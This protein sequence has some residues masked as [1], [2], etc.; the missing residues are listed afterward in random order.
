[1]RPS[2]ILLAAGESRRMGDANKLLLEV[3]GRPMLSWVVDA[4]LGA[5][6]SPDDIVAVTG[7]DAERV[8]DLLKAHH[9]RCVHHEHWK[10]GMGSSL[11][12]GARALK[13]RAGDVVLVMLGDLPELR[14]EHIEDVLKAFDP[15]SRAI[16]IPVHGEVP[17]HPALFDARFLGE[18]AQCRGDS[19]AKGVVRRH[20]GVVWRVEFEDSAVIRDVDTPQV[21]AELDAGGSPPVGCPDDSP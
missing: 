18:L 14:S 6:I 19:G 3:R 20:A 4:L 1:M 17:G 13:G 8:G 21:L 7:S 9:V 11:A 15:P 2:V 16:C 12:A 5:G 10:E